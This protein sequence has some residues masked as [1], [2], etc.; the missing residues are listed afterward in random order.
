MKL[1]EKF[2][3]KPLVAAIAVAY[4]SSHYS[5][6]A[7]E[8]S[9]S[10]EAKGFEI[11]VIE[12]T[13]RKRVENVQDV[14]L[15][16][17]AISAKELEY[18]QIQTTDQLTEVIPNLQFGSNAPSSGHNSAAVIFIRGIGQPDFI[19][20]TDPGVGLYIDG[21]YIARSIGSVTELLELQSIEVLRG[22][23]GTLF[24]RNTIGGAIS[25]TSKR[26]D[27]EFGGSGTVR[28]GSDNRLEF[29]GDVSIPFTDDFAIKATVADRSRDGYVTNL[30]TEEDLGDD[31]SFGARIG[32]EW[33]ISDTVDAYFSFDY[34]TEKENGS[35][36]VFNSLNTS[37]LFAQLAAGTAGPPPSVLGFG[38]RGVT[39][40][41]GANQICAFQNSAGENINNAGSHQSDLILNCGTAGNFDLGN[42][43]PYA[44]YAN[45]DL[46]STVDVYGASLTLN[47]SHD[48]FDIKSITALR[49][50]SYDVKRDADNTPLTI[51]HSENHDEIRQISQELQ[52]TGSA[53]DNKLAWVGGL[54]YF[55]EDVTF[56]N[57]VILPAK[58]VGALNNA[59][60]SDTTN[61][62]A[63]AQATW[64]VT[65]RL[66]LTG[67]LRYT[68]ETKKT[69]PN[70]HAIGNYNVP[71]P[72]STVGLR[73]GGPG[74]VTINNPFDA[75][76]RPDAHCIT[77]SDNELLYAK[78]ENSLKF[79]QVTPMGSIAYDL[80]ESSLLYATYSEGFKSGGFN[81]R[82]IQ[83]VPSASNPDG[84]T[85]IPTFKPEEAETIEFGFKTETDFLGGNI[86]ASG[87]LFSTQ[88]KN[89]H[90]VVRQGVAPITFNAGESE[91]RGF[92]FEGV[93][94]PTPD[95]FITWG[96]GYTE[97]RYKAFN[98]LL[99]D[100]LESA[101]A[102]HNTDPGN[103]PI[104]SEVPG[105]ID[106]DDKLAY[107]PEFTSSLGASY[108]IT[109]GSG[110]ITL[111]ADWYHQGD[112]FFDSVNTKFISQNA[113]D[114]L[115][116]SIT[117]ETDDFGGIK[118]SLGVKNITDE[119][120]RTAGNASFS[121][122]AYSESVYNRGRE[123]L[124]T[125][126]KAF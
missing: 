34:M 12:V 58:T 54:Y 33:F 15:S 40:S 52:I 80:G 91:I 73:C 105:L 36:T 6:H 30:L 13:A 16:I 46:L 104:P 17:T 121:G 79:K 31:N 2:T 83:P 87:A 11:E 68:S 24:G 103:N 29:I 8:Q 63:F 117:Y 51:L 3:V 108:Y 50:T 9:E 110:D 90:I 77:L 70:F 59:G 21:V 81:A 82:I 116:A 106:L 98:G 124:F 95:L 1:N 64:D 26:P 86:R 18:R 48:N 10:Q 84:V 25:L 122:S 37:G 102:A 72:F 7:Q 107:T 20:S 14:P 97:G 45:G 4:L 99:A 96:L 44:T 123:W 85:S 112:I 93:W 22:P 71:N 60:V 41:S 19:P 94:T 115:S 67:G 61:T 39:D 5:V 69:T 78:R 53:L 42:T 47:S 43:G 55:Q 114:L 100:K 89:Q 88:Y 35:P 109:T 92:E 28:L 76:N 56:D 66:H 27:S 118:A 65:E 101:T 49:D 38:D 23:Q 57:P 74:L 120:Y 32:A 75:I 119:F 111:R 126:T 113:I 62:A 125:L